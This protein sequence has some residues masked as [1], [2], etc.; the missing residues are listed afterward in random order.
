MEQVK[1]VYTDNIYGDTQIETARF[2]KEN[3]RFVVAPN[4]KETSLIEACRD[5]TR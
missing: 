5:A 4:H 1:V 3:Y 2:S